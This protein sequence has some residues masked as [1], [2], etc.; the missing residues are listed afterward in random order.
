MDEIIRCGGVAP[1]EAV[2]LREKFGRLK[3]EKIQEVALQREV[4]AGLRGKMGEVERHAGLVQIAHI[5]CRI[6]CRIHDHL[7]KRSAGLTRLWRLAPVGAWPGFKS[8]LAIAPF[9]LENP[10]RDFA[11]AGAGGNLFGHAECRV[12]DESKASSIGGFNP[13]SWDVECIW[14]TASSMP[15]VKDRSSVSAR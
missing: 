9:L 12:N 11:M 15:L 14:L 2:H 7:G 6:V 3:N 1:G 4:A 5:V 10:E 13:P 8:R